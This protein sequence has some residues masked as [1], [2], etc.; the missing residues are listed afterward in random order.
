MCLFLCFL[1]FHYS[2]TPVPHSALCCVGVGSG[3]SSFLHALMG[4]MEASA[5]ARDVSARLA[6]VGQRA[7]IQQGPLRDSI[8][9]GRP[10]DP[11]R[12]QDVLRSFGMLQDL[13]Q[14]PAGDL[15]ELGEHGISISGGQTQRLALARAAYADADVV[16]LGSLL[17]CTCHRFFS[18]WLRFEPRAR[19]VGVVSA[20]RLSPPSIPSFFP[21][22]PYHPS[23]HTHPHPHPHPSVVFIP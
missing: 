4:E 13:K 17:Y 2:S 10:Y 11:A 6:Y 8:T 23:R 21:H 14:F 18:G 22:S 16:L 19:S 7:W 3:K 1:V 5:G 20:S 9:F 15:T 12:V